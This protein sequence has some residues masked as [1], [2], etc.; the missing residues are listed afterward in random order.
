[1]AETI[2]IAIF[3]TLIGAVFGFALA[4]LAARNMMPNPWVRAPVR[5]FLEILRAFPEVVLAGFF[6]AILSLGPIPAVIAVTFHTIGALGKQF[7]EVIE[8]AD[9]K[10][11]EGLKAVGGNWFE[12]VVFGMVPQIMPNLISYTLLRVE[13]NVRAS[14]IIG[15]SAAAALVSFC[16]CRSAGAMKPRPLPSSFSCLPQLSRLTSFRP[17]CARSWWASNRSWPYNRIYHDNA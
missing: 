7:Y 6:L 2:N 9:M 3:S 17:G 12:R 14:T 1:M 16:A 11:D 5:R 13:I 10:P 8:N 15:A 4:F